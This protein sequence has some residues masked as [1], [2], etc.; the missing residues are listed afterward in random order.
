MAA[1]ALMQGGNVRVGIEDNIRIRANKLAESNADLVPGPGR[2]GSRHRNLL[3]CS[4]CDTSCGTQKAVG[5][6]DP[7]WNAFGGGQ[8]VRCH[9]L[10]GD[11]GLDGHVLDGKSA[12]R[13]TFRHN[14]A[15]CCRAFGSRFISPGR[16]SA[17]N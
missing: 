12:G 2:P 14:K 4:G 16:K 15:P 1:L 6:F 8:D 7:G 5:A 13:S 10:H 11:F 9:N 3:I 17:E